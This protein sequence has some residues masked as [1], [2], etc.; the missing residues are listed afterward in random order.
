MTLIR[1][2]KDEIYLTYCFCLVFDLY[3]SYGGGDAR[4]CRETTYL[5]DTECPSTHIPLSSIA[6][7]HFIANFNWGLGLETPPPQ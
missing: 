2:I 4:T 7:I 1:S 6:L 3:S 5:E